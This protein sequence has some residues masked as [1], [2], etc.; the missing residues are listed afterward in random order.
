MRADRLQDGRLPS[1]E[2][3]VDAWFD[4]NAFRDPLPRTY[5]NS[6]R[7]IIPGPG[8]AATDFSLF[9]EFP[10]REAMKFQLRGEFFNVFNRANFNY[11]IQANASVAA[12]GI[13]TQAQPPRRVQIALKFLF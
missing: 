11:P 5:G 1:G 2:R 9:K 8:Y 3:S 4:K 7:N 6:G 10:V 12:G 13:I